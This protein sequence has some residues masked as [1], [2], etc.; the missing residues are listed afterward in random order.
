MY[1]HLQENLNFVLRVDPKT[2]GY[3][4]S[5]GW[6]GFYVGCAIVT[7]GSMSTRNERDDLLVVQADGASLFR[8]GCGGIIYEMKRFLARL[9]KLVFRPE[10]YVILAFNLL[11]KPTLIKTV[12]RFTIS[13]S[14]PKGVNR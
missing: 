14:I 9:K 2:G 13:N 1:F 8:G 6:A 3:S 7:P 5:T 11:D 10:L 4:C 12:D